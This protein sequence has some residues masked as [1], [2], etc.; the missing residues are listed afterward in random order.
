MVS[1]ASQMQA[2]VIGQGSIGRR[3]ARLLAARGVRVAVVSSQADT[4]FPRF[5]TIAEALRAAMPDY[6]V[7]ATATAR[8]MEG[9]RALAEAGFRG[10]LLIEKP[11]AA[12]PDP[13]DPVGYARAGVAY[14]LRFHPALSALR[15][16]LRD[17]P[18]RVLTVHCGQHLSGWRPGRDYRAGYSADAAQGGGALRDLSHDL[19][20][21]EW[22]AGPAERVAAQGGNLGILGIRADEAWSIL[23]RTQAGTQCSV[24]LNYLDRPARR[25]VVATTAR[26]TL[27]LDLVAGT[28]AVNGEVTHFPVARDTTYIALHD[29]MLEAADPRLCTPD[30]AHRTD[31][32]IAAIETAARTETWVTP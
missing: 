11:L 32:L 6:I 21:L 20:Y 8:H 18:A 7:I 2:L 28:L 31:R 25:E 22:L 13:L 1:P 14:N 17:D 3:H 12:V 5:A 27:H 19:N 29:A 10:R 26:A 24:T 23:V 9:V 15:D 16:H 4:G 30:D